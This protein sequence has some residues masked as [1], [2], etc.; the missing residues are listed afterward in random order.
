MIG[1]QMKRDL[2]MRKLGVF[3]LNVSLN[4]DADVI[5]GRQNGQFG[6]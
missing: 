1:K 4:Y 2:G 5:A 3:L 6:K